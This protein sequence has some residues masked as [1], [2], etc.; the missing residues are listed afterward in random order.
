M[1]K[2]N[3]KL[4]VSGFESQVQE[5]LRL[6]S[7]V[8]QAS[9]G[10]DGLKKVFREQAVARSR[11]VAKSL[12]FVGPGGRVTVS[13]PDPLVES[14]RNGVKPEL[15]VEL[16]EAGIDGTELVTKKR[17]YTL[18]GTW[19]DW[20]EGI[21]A[22]WEKQGVP[23]PDGVTMSESLRLTDA[24]VLK[25]Q[26]MAAESTVGPVCKKVLSEGLRAPTVTIRNM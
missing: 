15:L 23:V 21:I 3:G 6:Q 4:A 11:G 10:L 13:L 18:T 22:G 26:A 1:A 25:L 7:V 8:K 9:D 17:V 14:S 2:S 19:I 5:A 16:A 24:G 12:E 20:F